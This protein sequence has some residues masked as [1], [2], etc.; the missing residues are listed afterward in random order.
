MSKLYN[1]LARI[2]D[3]FISSNESKYAK[4]VFEEISTQLRAIAFKNKLQP[5][6][7]PQVFHIRNV[8]PHTIE[9]FMKH[10]GTDVKVEVI[11]NDFVHGNCYE[12]TQIVSPQKNDGTISFQLDIVRHSLLARNFF[13]YDGSKGKESLKNLSNATDLHSII[14]RIEKSYNCSQVDFQYDNEKGKFVRLTPLNPYEIYLDEKCKKCSHRCKETE[15]SVMDFVDRC[16]D[17][18]EPIAVKTA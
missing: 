9:A 17:V 16:K 18:F 7:L 11:S 6:E 14:I 2:R 5:D 4:D 10:L 1:Q 3:D 15:Y 13:Q 12:V 8:P